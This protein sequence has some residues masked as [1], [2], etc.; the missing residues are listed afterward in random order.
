MW[1]LTGVGA[2]RCVGQ[3]EAASGLE[4]PAGRPLKS[5]ATGPVASD[6]SFRT[7]VASRISAAAT[8]TRGWCATVAKSPSQRSSCRAVRENRPFIHSFISLASS[9]PFSL[10]LSLS[11]ACRGDHFQYIIA[12]K[13]RFSHH[14]AQNAAVLIAGA[15][16]LNNQHGSWPLANKQM[17]TALAYAQ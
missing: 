17:A 15:N 3:F 10:N 14:I 6:G 2:Y 16:D 1:G 7:S 4:P 13:V 8:I 9:V 5:K 11:R 12:R